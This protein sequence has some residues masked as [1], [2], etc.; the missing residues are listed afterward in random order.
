MA[1]NESEAVLQLGG[2]GV[3][4]PEKMKRLEFLAK[5]SGF[6]RCEAMM[7][8]VKEMQVGTEVPPQTREKLW[9]EVE[10]EF[11]RPQIFRGSIFFGGFVVVAALS[12]AV[13]ARQA[14]DSALNAN[15]LIALSHESRDRFHGLFK[16]G[17]AGVSVD[18]QAVPRSAPEKLVE[19]DAEALRLDVPKCSVDRRDGGH[20]HRSTAPIGAFVEVLPG[21][22]NAASIATDEQR[23]DVIGQIAG[24]REFAT[25]QRSVTETIDAVFGHKLEC[26]EVSPRTTHSHFRV[27]DFH[28][29]SVPFS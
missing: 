4:Q 7:R 1:P 20:G 14:R 10:V 5:A 24:H 27:D 2:R 21:V 8:V 18:H 28:F 16:V 12:D 13:G 6:D 9:N 23:R 3:F 29:S 11:G 22:C 19:R 15:G 25:I 17:A 26:H